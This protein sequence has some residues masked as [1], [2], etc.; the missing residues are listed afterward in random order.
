MTTTIQRLKPVGSQSAPHIRRAK[1]DHEFWKYD[2]RRVEMAARV[3][4]VTGLFPLRGLYY[5]GYERPHHPPASSPNGRK[6]WY[7]AHVFRLVFV[8]VYRPSMQS[9]HRYYNIYENYNAYG[10]DRIIF[11]SKILNAQRTTTI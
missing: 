5:H 9:Y 2:Y 1:G 7:T 8:H 3:A 10:G 11:S 4:P 6:Y